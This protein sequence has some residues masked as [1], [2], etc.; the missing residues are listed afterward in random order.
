MSI[1]T[2]EELEGLRRAGSVVAETLREVRAHVAAGVTTGELDAVAAEIFARRGA[3]S[4]PAL[5]YGFPGTICIAVNDEAVHGI[6]GRRRLRPGDLVK[7]DVTAELD[8][9]F[10]DAAVS[11]PVGPPSAAVRR[12]C[13]AAEAG[14][15][16]GM[17]A[18]R[19]GRPLNA[20]GGAVQAAVEARGCSVL[21]ELNGHGI[22]RAIH[23]PPTVPAVYDPR[24]DTPLTEGLVITIE[25]IVSTGGA[26]VLPTAD[27]WTVV[28]ADG[29][30]AAH[31]EHTL[32][33]TADSPLVL[34]A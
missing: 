32:V 29:A 24:L 23:E 1:E 6:P 25:P 21:G 22:G 27:G 11:V 4:A 28:T 33:I 16:Q 18:A 13:A 34:T 14:L 9:F 3:R 12:L 26:D 19:A 2:D 8:G 31:V 5:A 17:R 30:P 10:A 15:R 7:L 20:I